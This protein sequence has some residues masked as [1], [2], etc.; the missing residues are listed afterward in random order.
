MNSIKFL[1]LFLIS[2]LLSAQGS[3]AASAM[4]LQSDSKAALERLYAANPK[5]RDLGEKAY[6]VLIFPTVVKAGVVMFGAQRGDGVLWESGQV[7]GYYNTTS[8]SY[9]PQIGVQSFSYALF[10]MTKKDLKGLNNSAGFNLGAAPSLVIADKGAAGS[11]SL[12][13]LQGI[14]AFIFGQQ[15]LMAGLGLQGT[16]ISQYTPSN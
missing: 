7:A 4:Q 2:V 1:V 15:G 3:K 13:T 14:K 6:A 16:K 5:A 10:F 9:G 8:A 12:Y 11:A